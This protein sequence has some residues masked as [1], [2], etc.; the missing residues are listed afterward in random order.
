LFK[1]FADILEGLVEKLGATVAGIALITG[2]AIWIL[3]YFGV[4]AYLGQG[5]G[6]MGLGIG[7]IAFGKRAK[8]AQEIMV[9]N[10]AQKRIENP[11]ASKESA[12]PAIQRE[13]N[14]QILVSEQ[15]G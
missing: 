13:M 14:K 9:T 2:G 6:M 7:V 10:E 1:T 5:L 4:P 15:K 12:V 11:T 3:P 8:K